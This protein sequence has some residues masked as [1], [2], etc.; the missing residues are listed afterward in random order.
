MRIDYSAIVN[1][2]NRYVLKKIE[3]CDE[4]SHFCYKDS[5]QAIYERN[6]GD[7][8]VEYTLPLALVTYDEAFTILIAGL[9]Q[10]CWDKEDRSIIEDMARALYECLDEQHERDR[11]LEPVLEAIEEYYC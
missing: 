6:L 10:G 7:T 5:L 8:C 2:H 11:K 9:I 1:D 3:L 4:T